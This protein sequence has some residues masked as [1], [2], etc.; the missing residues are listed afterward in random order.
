MQR[1][2]RGV[3]ASLVAL[4]AAAAI[5]A[6]SGA[7][8]VKVETTIQAAINEA[9]SGDT[10]VVPP[11][12]YH[13]GGLVV[14]QD[15][16]TIR[17]SKAAVLDASGNSIGIRVGADSISGDPPQC[18]PLT[19]DDFTLKGLT[20][21][22]ASFT[23]IFLVGVDGFRVTGGRYLDNEEYGVFPRC[24]RDGL[25]DHNFGDGGVDTGETG[26]DATVY[27]GVDDEITVKNN[28]LVNGEIGIELEN[29]TDS[30][31]RDNKLTGNVNGML[32]VVL[33]DLPTTSTED[34]LIERNVIRANN[35]P[36]PFPLPPPL[37]DDLQLLP[38]G[39]GILNVGGDAITMRR[40][41]VNKNNS[42]GIGIVENPFGFGPPDDNRVVDNTVLHN[43]ADPDVRA[44]L[45][46]DIAYDGSG[47]NNCFAGNVFKTDDPE[48]IVSQFPC[49]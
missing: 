6:T 2:K 47:T 10:I 12:T 39:S 49:D 44:S 36:N 45:S 9:S 41:V 22:D 17:G 13:E 43:G 48:G 34:A 21:R 40:N 23:G 1:V 27:V 16:L 26:L 25:I 14:T 5:P 30:I 42:F 46:A 28:K 20:I 8:V 32:V 11:G 33:P 37:F 7:K 38:S 29:T 18:P 3:L 4:A 31:V 24:S 35:V 15:D 19:V